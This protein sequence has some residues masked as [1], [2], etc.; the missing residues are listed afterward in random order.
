MKKQVSN[1][2][3]TLHATWK[4]KQYVTT[5]GGERRCSID[6]NKWIN[7]KPLT[8]NNFVLMLVFVASRII[9]HGGPRSGDIV[10]S[11][12]STE[13]SKTKVRL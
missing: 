7:S 12:T 11:V 10:D 1:S 13:F 2:R 6:G 4:G 5:F 8:K 9:L 3:P